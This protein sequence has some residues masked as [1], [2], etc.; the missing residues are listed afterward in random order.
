M[1]LFDNVSPLDYRYYGRDKSFEKLKGYFSENSRVKYLCI[2]ELALVK[3]L[4]R[5]KICSE[6]TVKEI[7]EAVKKVTAEEMYIEEDRTKHDIRSLANCIRNKVSEES[8]PFVHFGATSFDIVDTANALRFK[9]AVQELIIPKLLELEKVL[10]ELA[11]R[12][13]ETV[14]IGRTHGQHAEPLTFGLAIACHAGR[15]AGRIK[16]IERSSENLSGKFSGAV[17]AY[18]ATSLLVENPIEL[19]K[20]I[21]QE[22]GLKVGLNST[23]IAEPE[24]LTDLMH[25]LTSCFG[26]L[27]NFSDDMRN[28]QRSEISEVA[29]AF[30]KEQ[31]G[32]STMPHKRN[33]LNF[34]N[35]KSFWKHFMPQMT[36]VYLD[37]ISDHQRDL[38]NSASGRFFPELPVALYLSAERLQKVCSKIV[39]DKESMK[40]N[41]DKN[42]DFIIA[43]PLY[44]LLALHN[45]P[46]AH[47]F[48]KQLTLKA[49]VEKKP[50]TQIVQEEPEMQKYLKKFSEQQKEILSMPEKYLG[51]SVEKTE[52]LCNHCKKELGI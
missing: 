13:K 19:E 40:R 21:M 47:E 42:K 48:V 28:L 16:E 35:V 49:Q 8:K 15:L 1:D 45:H 50:F 36:A 30:G 17:G 32:S 27:A 7:E 11:L 34:E 23:Q 2:V 39:V 10:I 22:L 24:P 5:K 12:E 38:T 41:F 44:I 52:M 26:V 46:D 37:Q 3:A 51:K 25:A 14:Q 43:E 20:E 29:E 18:N 31:V 4:A 33:P 6:K 9:K